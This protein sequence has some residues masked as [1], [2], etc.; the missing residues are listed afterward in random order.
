MQEQQHKRT[1]VN[2]QAQEVQKQHGSSAAIPE[3]R[4]QGS[5]GGGS[6]G[7][8]QSSVTTLCCQKSSF[9]VTALNLAMSNKQER[10][11]R[12]QRDKEK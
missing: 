8:V 12:I 2:I 1:R 5:R 10:K 9:S 3:L 11:E 7:S 4:C 6:A